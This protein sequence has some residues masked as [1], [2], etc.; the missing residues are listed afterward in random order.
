MCGGT[1]NAQ[2][3]RKMKT[4]VTN[5]QAVELITK[6]GHL[7]SIEIELVDEYGHLY[8]RSILNNGVVYNTRGG[9]AHSSTS[10]KNAI[11][12][13]KIVLAEAEAVFSVYSN[14]Y[15]SENG[16]YKII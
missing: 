11:E 6:V 1:K 3:K 7:S 2:G 8:N 16:D 9:N 13:V 12:A 4:E 5:K 14:Y 15:H 10:K